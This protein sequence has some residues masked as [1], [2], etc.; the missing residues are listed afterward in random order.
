[1][2]KDVRELSLKDPEYL[3]QV[4]ED[5]KR[6]RLE[7]ARIPFEEKIEALKRLQRIAR[8]FRSLRKKKP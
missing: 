4:L 8:E 5:K 6:W 2:R 3:Q 1:M 7:R